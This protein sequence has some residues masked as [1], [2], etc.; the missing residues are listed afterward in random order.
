MRR[1]NCRAHFKGSR[2]ASP[3]ASEP[4]RSTGN[5][6]FMRMANPRKAQIRR[7]ALVADTLFEPEILEARAVVNTIDHD[8]HAL[9]R[10]L[11]TSHPIGEEQDRAGHILGQL[12]LDL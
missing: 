4:L 6:L 2:T 7:A 8:G 1:P 5:G 12:P 3:V 10:G 9:Q 11:P